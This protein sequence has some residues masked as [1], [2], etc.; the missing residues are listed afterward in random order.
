MQNIKKRV[1]EVIEDEE[2][3]AHHDTEPT[4]TVTEDVPQQQQQQQL[5]QQEEQDCATD[6]AKRHLLEYGYVVSWTWVLQLLNNEMVQKEKDNSDRETI[7]LVSP[8]PS[9]INLFKK[10]LFLS[11][12]PHTYEFPFEFFA[13]NLIKIGQ[14]RKDLDLVSRSSLSEDCYQ[15]LV[16]FFRSTNKLADVVVSSKQQSNNLRFVLTD[17]SFDARCEKIA[18]PSD[19]TNILRQ[20]N[21]ASTVRVSICDLPVA[22]NSD[23][24]LFLINNELHVDPETT[25]EC[26]GKCDASKIR[27]LIKY[28]HMAKE[29]VES[30]DQHSNMLHSTPRSNS[31]WS[32]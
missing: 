1:Q 12:P 22:Q 32:G 15:M 8:V 13:V 31:S 28:I 2:D 6:D 3:S 10:C 11:Q 26:N 5:Q 30:D 14:K 7:F 17:S 9:R 27:T 19:V 18:T 29:A 23:Q 20:R 25:I 16:Q 4:V 21:R 24:L